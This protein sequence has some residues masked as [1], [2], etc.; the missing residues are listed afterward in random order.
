MRPAGPAIDAIGSTEHN[1]VVCADGASLWASVD[2]L[3][4]L[5]LPANLFK[6]HLLRSP[7]VDGEA[8]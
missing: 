5:L 2:H 4:A 1:Y 8:A 3:L 7:N 6:L